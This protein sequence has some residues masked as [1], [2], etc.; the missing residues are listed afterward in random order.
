[1][2]KYGKSIAR[3]GLFAVGEAVSEGGANFIKERYP[4]W[5][6]LY[7]QRRGMQI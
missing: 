1:M 4:L 2:Q 6:G 5:G 3:D 7:L